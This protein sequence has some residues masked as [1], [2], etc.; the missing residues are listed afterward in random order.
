MPNREVP[1]WPPSAIRDAEELMRYAEQASAETYTI[2]SVV[3][4]H[5]HV[6]EQWTQQTGIVAE[7]IRSAG[8]ALQD[9][10]ALRARGW[11][12][13]ARRS[14]NTCSATASR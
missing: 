7:A 6:R 3:V 9:A 1:D 13:R 8:L 11:P 4:A 10:A 12:G 14:P 5:R 2:Q